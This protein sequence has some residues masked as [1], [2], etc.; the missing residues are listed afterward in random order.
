MV[1]GIINWIIDDVSIGLISQNFDE[2][3]NIK[4]AESVK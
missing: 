3:T 2:A 4:I 1:N